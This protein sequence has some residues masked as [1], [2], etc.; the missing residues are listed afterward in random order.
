MKISKRSTNKVLTMALSLMFLLT[1]SACNKASESNS[2]NADQL[3]PLKL[4]E[5]INKNGWVMFSSIT[6]SACRAQ[7]KLFGDAFNTITSIECNPHAE[8]TQTELCL[9]HQIKKT[10]TWIKFDGGVYKGEE[11]ARIESF[12]LLDDLSELTACKQN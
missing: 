6:C 9:K 7:R 5:C 3:D 10:P 12:H 1:M 11:L 4:A 2:K 8:N